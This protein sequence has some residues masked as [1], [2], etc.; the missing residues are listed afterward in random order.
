[1]D[2]EAALDNASGSLSG[3]ATASCHFTLFSCLS[4]IASKQIGHRI[5]LLSSEVLR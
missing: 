5:H 3:R 4:F 2:D 1:M